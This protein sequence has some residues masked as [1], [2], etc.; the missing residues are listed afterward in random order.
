[1]K[2]GDSGS[3]V[4]ALQKAL[5]AIGF[6]TTVDGQFGAMTEAAVKALQEANGLVIDGIVGPSTLQKIDQLEAAL[7][8]KSSTP[9]SLV[10]LIDV[11]H[12]DDVIDW[13]KVKAAG[14]A[15]AFM[16]ASEGI[17]VKDASFARNWAETRKN[18]IVRGAYHF[19]RP[20]HDG[21][22][23]AQNLLNSMGQL[24]PDDLPV[25]CDLE[26]MDGIDVIAVLGR[27]KVFM[28]RI[29]LITRKTPI[30]YTMP[31]QLAQLGHA[32]EL[33]QYPLYLAA[34]GHSLD[35]VKVPAPFTKVTFLQTT[36]TGTVPGVARAG[37]EDVFNGSMAEFLAFSKQVR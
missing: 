7:P 23:Q 31:D 16:K 24:Q 33:A 18:G 8:K 27:V 1:M 11:Y 15:G 9:S 28:D 30:L 37:D 32:K 20:Q 17:N 29:K 26:V 10:K 5:N 22:A 13:A 21:M 34:P 36:F 14:F 19:F 35:N 6:G 4:V 3:Q 25:T 2:A 12:G